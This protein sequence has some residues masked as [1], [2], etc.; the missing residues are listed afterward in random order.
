MKNKF[1]AGSIVIEK[2]FPG[3]KLIVSRIAHKLYHC[4]S[5]EGP[6]RKEWLYFERELAACN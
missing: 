4:L 6:R 1:P 3:K 5:D 2:L